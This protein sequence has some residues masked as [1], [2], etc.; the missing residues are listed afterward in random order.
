MT[1]HRILT[2]FFSL[3]LLALA[4]CDQQTAPPPSG[5]A[6]VLSQSEVIEQVDSE[7]TRIMV[8]KMG[9]L[10]GL[11][12]WHSGHAALQSAKDTSQPDALP[13]AYERYMSVGLAYLDQPPRRT[14]IIGLGS[15]RSAAYQRRAVPQQHIDVSEVDRE[16]I[17]IAKQYFGFTEDPNLTVSNMDGRVFLNRQPDASYDLILLDAFSHSY[18]PFHLTTREFYELAERKLAPGGVVAQ[19]VVPTIMLFNS[20]YLTMRA[21]FDHVDAYE[22]AGN[23]ILLGYNGAALPDDVLVARARAMQPRVQVYYELPVLVAA[24]AQL[25]DDLEGKV[26]TDDFADSEQLAAQPARQDEMALPAAA[27]ESAT[28]TP[29]S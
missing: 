13:I 29:H 25:R 14:A 5:G 12:F 1:R 18:A 2:A 8:R 6:K 3:P 19:N 24:R 22:A 27:A 23:V 16:V 7:Y 10:L 11:Y 17:R 4:G 21:V 26:L 9:P 20:S 28:P 15:G